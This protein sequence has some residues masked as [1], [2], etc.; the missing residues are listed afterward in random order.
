VSG[1]GSAVAS[2]SGTRTGRG[3]VALLAVIL[4]VVTAAATFVAIASLYAVAL[5]Q[6]RARLREYVRSQARLIEQI[7]AHEQKYGHFVPDSTG[8]GDARDA[9]LTQLAQAHARFSGAGRTGEFKLAERRGDSIVYLLSHRW[10]TAGLPTAIQWQQGAG[11]PMQQALSGQSGTMVGRD[12]RGVTVV[13]AFEPVQAFD[14]GA[15][16]K[17]DLAEVRMPFVRAGLIAGLI[18]L[19][20]IGVGTFLFFRVTDPMLLRLTESEARLRSE[21]DFVD[22]LFRATSDTVFVFESATGKAVRWNDAF[23][24]ISGY[25]DEE[26]ARLRAPDSYHGP[27]DLIRTAEA[28]TRIMEQGRGPVELTLLTKEGRAIPFEHSVAV[29][30]D[31]NGAPRWSISLGRDISERKRAERELKRLNQELAAKA[32]ELEQLVYAASHDLRSPLVTVMG[33]VGELRMSLKDLAAEL[34]PTDATAEDRERLTAVTECDIP[35]EL[36]YI[37][38]GTARMD[39]LLNGLLTLSR[40]GRNVI[41]LEDLDMDSLVAEVLRSTRFAAK[42]AGATIDVSGL[43]CCVGDRTM[44]SQVVANLVDN[45]IK[46]RS[47]ERPLLLGISGRREGE[48]AVYCVEDNGIGIDSDSIQ[49]VLEPFYQVE[50]RQSPGEGLGLTIVARIVNQLRGS[51]WVESEEGKGSRFF[52]SLPAAGNATPTTRRDAKRED[53][54]AKREEN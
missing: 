50:P 36:K 25:T 30:P 31:E 39:G 29:V 20:L 1:D 12:Y 52:F 27:E 33:Y 11:T 44:V 53:R 45:A 18:A 37:E 21:L 5:S 7:A 42:E 23:R 6:T 22:S 47:P 4:M 48:R 24:R 13:A 41:N 54:D 16:A 8:H 46:Y 17:I 51:V 2:D 38:A 40:L 43:P 14:W 19:L 15:V 26:I 28:G 10:Q 3:R 34:E 49:H 32:E 35:R 9:L